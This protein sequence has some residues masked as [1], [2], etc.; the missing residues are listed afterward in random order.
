MDPNELLLLAVVAII[1]G[2]IAQ[3]TSG[4]SRGGLIVNLGLGF[5]GAFVGVYLAR[6]FNAPKI[7]NVK[8]GT[9]DFPVIYSLV[10]SVFSVALVGF[11]VKPRKR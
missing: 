3:L 1:C 10:G 8:F 2:S 4:Y 5:C 6:Y 11:L 7:I 9:S